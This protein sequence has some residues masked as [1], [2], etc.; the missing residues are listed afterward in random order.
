[1]KTRG[2]VWWVAGIAL[3]LLVAGVLSQ[4]AS[5]EPDGLERVATDQGILEQ[6]VEREGLLA[7]DS[8]GGLLGVVL[9]LA[10]ALALSWV[11]RRRSADASRGR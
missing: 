10:A 1:M 6:A 5:G 8:A 7:Y 11:L 3:A 2:R 4:F 9:V